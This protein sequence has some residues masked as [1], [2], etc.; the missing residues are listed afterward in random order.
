MTNTPISEPTGRQSFYTQRFPLTKDSLEAILQIFKRYDANGADDYL[1]ALKLRNPSKQQILLWNDF[2]VERRAELDKEL[3]NL[4]AYMDD[5]VNTFAINNPHRFKAILKMF[6][7]I[8]DYTRPLMMIFNVFAPP[9]HPLKRKLR[10]HS[11][12]GGVK[13]SLMSTLLGGKN[14][15]MQLIPI[16]QYSETVQMFFQN[17]SS[18]FDIMHTLMTKTW[19]VLAREKAIMDD[20]AQCRF[21]FTTDREDIDTH[22]GL[23]L[24]FINDL[25]AKF[26]ELKQKKKLTKLYRLF[27]QL[28]LDAFAQQHYHRL[29]PSEM[30]D[31]CQIL[32]IE[33]QLATMSDNDTEM[34]LFG[35]DTEHVQKVVS[36]VSRFDSLLPTGCKHKDFTNLLFCFCEWAGGK[37]D[38]LHKNYDYFVAHYKGTA[39]NAFTKK[40]LPSWDRIKKIRS[41]YVRC[42][43]N[44]KSDYQDFLKQI[45]RI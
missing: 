25:R 38:Q 11:D 19:D 40:K 31:L 17:L 10:M 43:N 6:D 29:T 12:N 24:P 41:E 18:W 14:T 33:R 8:H 26:E 4:M 2:V 9:E 30:I 5:F 28:D 42:E 45:D 32:F 13:T 1:Q 21:I 20:K 27:T 44:R 22:L 39:I 16:E 36:V 34:E 23:E 7:E 35:P 37:K 3:M 15:Q